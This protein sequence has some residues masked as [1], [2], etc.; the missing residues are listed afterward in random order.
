MSAEALHEVVERAM[1]DP[2]FRELLA[3]DPDTALAQYD[4]SPAERSRFGTG[5]ARAEPLD[6]RISKSDL[7]AGIGARTSTVDISPP[8]RSVKHKS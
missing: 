3:R 1:T 8:S 2:A 7:A 4:L 6:P 5:S